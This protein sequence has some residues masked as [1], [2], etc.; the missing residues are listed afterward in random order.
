MIYISAIIPAK[1]KI[2]M[3]VSECVVVQYVLIDGFKVL[4]IGRTEF[5]VKFI[6]DPRNGA[7]RNEF[8]GNNSVSD[9]I[10]NELKF[11]FWVYHF[12]FNI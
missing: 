12:A 1:H 7:C 4:K 3:T 10:A 9:F 5:S 6:Q 11:C 2:A 8:F